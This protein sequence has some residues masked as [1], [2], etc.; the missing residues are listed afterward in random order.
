MESAAVCDPEGRSILDAEIPG[1][2]NR[3]QRRRRCCDWSQGGPRLEGVCEYTSCFSGVSDPGGGIP[4]VS[5]H[6]QA[7]KGFNLTSHSMIIVMILNVGLFFAVMVGVLVGE[8]MFG[9]AGF[10]G[11]GGIGC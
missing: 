9:R 5:H 3:D 2:T 7:W 11:A 1:Q 10:H 4:A 6:H 8:L